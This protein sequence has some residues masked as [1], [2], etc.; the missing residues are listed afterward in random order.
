MDHQGPSDHKNPQGQDLDQQ[1]CNH[2]GLLLYKVSRIPKVSQINYRY[3]LVPFSVYPFSK[4]KVAV[5]NKISVDFINM[6]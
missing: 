2:A 3:Y 5:N 1:H 6:Y 4:V